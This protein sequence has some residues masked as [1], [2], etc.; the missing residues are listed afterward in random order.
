MF[1]SCTYCGNDRKQVM[2]VTTPVG[3]RY[4][5]S[6][7]CYAEYLGINMLWRIENNIHIRP[8]RRYYESSPKKVHLWMEEPVRLSDGLT[9]KISCIL[10]ILRNGR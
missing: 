9:M 4:F 8:Q 5:C 3:I 6:D 7:R 2:T 1:R 10:K